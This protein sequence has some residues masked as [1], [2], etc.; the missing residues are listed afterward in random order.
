MFFKKEFATD[1]GTSCASMNT[2]GKRTAEKGPHKDYNAYQDFD[3]RE[4]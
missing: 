2:T 1:V 4:F 3:K